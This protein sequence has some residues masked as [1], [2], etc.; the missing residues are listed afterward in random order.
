MNTFTRWI[1]VKNS[2][3]RPVV[4]VLSIIGF[5]ASY[6]YLHYA[7]PIINIDI[8]ITGS[9]AVQ[10]G[11]DV[12][13]VHPAWKLNH[14]SHAL[15]FEHNQA[16]QNFA[17]LECGG[18][19]IFIDMIKKKLYCP[20][21]WHIR[22]FKER[23]PYELNLYLTPEGKPHGFKLNIPENLLLPEVSTTQARSIAQ[24]HAAT[25]WNI[26]FEVYEEIESSQ[27]ILPNGRVDH[28]FVYKRN[29]AT[30]GTDGQYRV[31]LVVAGDQVVQIQAW[32]HV[33]ESFTKK[34]EQMRSANITLS[35]GMSLIMVALY[36]VFGMICGLYCLIKH[37]RLSST[38]PLYVASTAT[39]LTLINTINQLPIRYMY[40]ST[41][42]SLT[43]YHF[44]VGLEILKACFATFIS[45]LALCSV[46][47]G[48]DRWAFPDRVQLFKLLT[49]YG[50]R[51]KEFV[52]ETTT[53]YITLGIFLGLVTALYYFF[54]QW[55]G[56]WC[57][58]QITADPNILATYAPWFTSFFR[59]LQAGCTEEMLFRTLPLAGALLL[60][61]YFKKERSFLAL[62]MII[63]ALLFAGAHVN[64]PQ[65]PAY[66]R[67]VELIP[68]SLLFGYIYL[69]FG[70]YASMLV[71]TLYDLIL[72]STCIFASHAPTS[73]VQQVLLVGIILFPLALCGY[74]YLRY[75]LQALPN[76]MHNSSWQPPQMTPQSPTS[77]AVFTD[78]KRQPISHPTFM[79]WGVSSLILMVATLG[80]IST[81]KNSFT[82]LTMSRNQAIQ[83]ARKQLDSMLGMETSTT[84]TLEA[85]PY[86][87][88]NDIALYDA[89]SY[90]WQSGTKSQYQQLIGSYLADSFWYVRCM[91]FTGTLQE[92]IE[93][94]TFGITNTGEVISFTHTVA[95]DTPGAFLSKPEARGK[96]LEALQMIYDLSLDDVREVS[97]VQKDTPGHRVFT[98]TFQDIRSSVQTLLPH[99]EDDQARI[100]I[101]VTGDQVSSY[102]RTLFVPE[103]W[104]R[105][106]TARNTT[107]E[108][109]MMFAASLLI[110]CF[111]IA[112]A[113]ILS[114]YLMSFEIKR[115]L[116]WAGVCTVLLVLSSLNKF[117][118]SLMG[119]S[120]T[121]PI[122]NQLL[123]YG[124][125]MLIL[126]LVIQITVTIFA[127]Q[128]GKKIPL[129]TDHQTPE[130]IALQGLFLGAIG[131]G[132]TTLGYALSPHLVPNHS[133]YTQ[134]LD[135]YGT[136]IPSM[137]YV[138]NALL[139][140]FTT[141]TTGMVV[142]HCKARL[143]SKLLEW[144]YLL[145]IVAASSI[146]L[147][148]KSDIQSLPHLLLLSAI[149][150]SIVMVLLHTTGATS[151]L[152]AIPTYLV[153]LT[154]DILKHS[155]LQPYATAV[156]HGV[157]TLTVVWVLGY[158]WFMYL[159]TLDQERTAVR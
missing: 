66:F 126:I 43:N 132:I 150:T 24:E 21:Q 142:L 158:W 106:E 149:L 144:G 135:A 92:R 46:A 124:S 49:P 53:A 32:V 147:V 39:I 120:S 153:F 118:S 67:L 79:A 123:M 11:N 103:T 63:Q 157:G 61:H 81:Y 64:Y 70:L 9:Q 119:F 13:N 116:M 44:L 117:P 6:Q 130:R 29:D 151:P 112:C 96:A 156:V 122:T 17:E 155:M 73:I 107:I 85:Q 77:S 154:S 143:Q 30:L 15:K 136:Y 87:I 115:Y 26:D 71:H 4:I 129:F 41:E 141:A 99:E 55:C 148:I 3:I 62:G 95:E 90:A 14:H 91:R 74:Y 51:S 109:F 159:Y 152:I 84:W 131:V 19:K 52:R 108:T 22:Y 10:K 18:V 140:L 50:I 28:T 68:V 137:G 16:V 45:T 2:Y 35:I 94:Y 47:E 38:I 134:L 27:T 86:I 82:T 7:T 93:G 8:P 78:Q 48:L 100:T 37:R 88:K 98:F 75:K 5:I 25:N 83:C 127:S 125:L 145:V 42:L 89:H 59:A 121:I 146:Q 40:Y 60:G 65:M 110:L 102:R 34:F 133:S 97:V 80:I 23:D 1:T 12:V 54:I 114:T 138:A 139:I 111:V 20:Y 33:P 105:Q 113:T 128:F 57:P 76:N 104:K 72:M 56:W 36:L 58:A 101:V 69:Q 31:T